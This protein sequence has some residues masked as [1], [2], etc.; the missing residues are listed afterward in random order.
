MKKI[1]LSALTRKEASFRLPK[2]IDSAYTLAEII[3]VMLIIAVIV[4]VSIGITKAKLDN[5]VSYTYYNAYSSLRKISAE[6]LAD[7][8]P[9]DPEYKQAFNANN[10]E[11]LALGDFNNGLQNPVFSLKNKIFNIYRDVWSQPALAACTI[12]RRTGCYYCGS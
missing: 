12:D 6:M 8:N 11:N 2:F 9:K 7:W 3:I 4:A 10:H 5:I 1:N